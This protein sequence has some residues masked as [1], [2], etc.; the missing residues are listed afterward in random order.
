MA[1]KPIKKPIKKPV[2]NPGGGPLISNN[3]SFVPG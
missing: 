3:G 2:E 1:K